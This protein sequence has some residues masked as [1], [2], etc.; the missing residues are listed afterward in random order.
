MWMSPAIDDAWLSATAALLRRLGQS[1][2]VLLAVALIGF[3]LFA[4]AGDPVNNMLGQDA[5]LAERQALRAELGLDRGFVAQFATFVSNAVQGEFGVSYRL[6][7][8]V[9]SLLLERLPATL[10][11]VLVASLM[12]L[13][14]GVPLGIYCALARRGWAARFFMTISLLGISVP[15]FVIGIGLIFVFAVRLQ[16]LPSF[17]RGETVALGWWNTGL[18]TA[19]G[20]QSIILPASTLAM[21]QLA[22]IMRLVRTEMLGVLGTDFVRFARARGLNVR[23]LYFRHALKNASIPVITVLGLQL[24][25]LIAFSI[26]TEQVFQWPGIGSLFLQAIQ[27]ADIPILAA[28]LMMVALIF[29]AINFALDLLYLAI[30]PRLRVQT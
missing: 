13:L 24:G 14:A 10:E 21:F 5:T 2:L 25:S 9:A 27:F 19:S 29:V 1:L 3:A 18:L 23:S 15:T 30:D 28:Y 26:I 4:Y 7:R 11:L 16:W 8:P 20:W 17:G 6:Q 12:A 22:L